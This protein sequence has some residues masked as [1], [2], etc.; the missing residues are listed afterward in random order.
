MRAVQ[1]NCLV[2]EVAAGVL[3]APWLRRKS[4][5]QPGFAVKEVLHNCSLRIDHQW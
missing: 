2:W 5:A 4:R 3:I 1:P